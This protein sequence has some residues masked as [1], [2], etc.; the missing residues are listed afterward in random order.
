[1]CARF[2]L[3]KAKRELE[4]RFPVDDAKGAEYE[5]SYNVA[6]SQ[7]RPVITIAGDVRVL[8][9]M[10]WGL[11]PEWA[12]DAKSGFKMI[13]ARA[14]TLT[15][16]ASFK[17][18]LRKTRCLIPASGFYEWAH[19]NAKTK[20][21]YYFSLRGG[22]LFAFA[23]LY[24]VWHAGLSDE[25]RTFT[26]I[27]TEANE[28]M[29]PVHHRMPVILGRKDESRWLDPQITEPEALLTLLKPYPAQEMECWQVSPYI[30]SWKNQGPDCI[31]PHT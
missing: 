24:S 15:E 23:G 22:G 14:E 27:T 11:V 10:R 7:S 21:P 26:I 17:T 31:R 12:G 29:K 30:N 19:P 5:P 1:M 28:I 8:S 18:P 25:L 9:L 3:A 16:K 6:P 20:I 2:S 4:S 13:N